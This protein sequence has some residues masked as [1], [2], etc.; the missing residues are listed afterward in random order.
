[1]SSIIFAEYA[2][3]ERNPRSMWYA[4]STAPS[5]SISG[6]MPVF[7][8]PSLD[9]RRARA[10]SAIAS[11]MRVLVLARSGGVAGAGAAAVVVSGAAAGALLLGTACCP[12]LRAAMR[13]RSAMI[14]SSSCL[15]VVMPAAYRILRSSPP[16]ISPSGILPPL[17]RPRRVPFLAMLMTLAMMSAGAP[18]CRARLPTTYPTN[19]AS[20]FLAE[21]FFSSR[22]AR[23]PLMISSACAWSRAG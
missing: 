2:A 16:A 3:N 15:A 7:R 5:A 22:A 11:V 9:F 18:S 21:A 17:L 4:A 8:R 1:M 6:S 10:A 14:A 13:S 19:L 12:A 20:A 23:M